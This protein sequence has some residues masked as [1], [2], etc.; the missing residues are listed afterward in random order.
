MLSPT[1]LAMRRQIVL[2]GTLNMEIN[3]HKE[4]VNLNA[5]LIAFEIIE[6]FPQQ[7]AFLINDYITYLGN[8]GK[9]PTYAFFVWHGNVVPS[10]II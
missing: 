2:K 8:S 6:E 4:M 5:R 7:Y 3:F 9:F 10:L 1:L